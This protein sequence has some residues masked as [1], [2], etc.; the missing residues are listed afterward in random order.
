MSRYL[1]NVIVFSIILSTVPPPR[2]E[3]SVNSGQFHSDSSVMLLC[4]INLPVTVNSEVTVAVLWFDPTGQLRNSS[5]VSIS[6]TYEVTNVVFQSSVTIF[7]YVTSVNNGDYT[8][9]AS[10]IP[11]SLHVTGISAVGRKRVSISG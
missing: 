9:N 3:I 5:N 2:I 4:T 1:H 8:C 11:T 6:N 7:N 10:V